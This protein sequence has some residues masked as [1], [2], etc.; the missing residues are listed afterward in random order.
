MDRFKDALQVSEEE[1]AKAYEKISN[2]LNQ[3]P[4]SREQSL[5]ITN[6][7]NSALWAGAAVRVSQK[8]LDK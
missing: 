5:A 6:L 2:L 1:L 4:R 3:L 8:Q 7:E